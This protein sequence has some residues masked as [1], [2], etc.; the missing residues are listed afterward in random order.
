M[1][2]SQAV[3]S[4]SK[5]DRGRLG[6][7][8]HH[9]GGASGGR[10]ADGVGSTRAHHTKEAAAGCQ[11]GAPSW[12]EPQERH[13]KRS[14]EAYS[15]LLGD[16]GRWPA[17]AVPRSPRTSALAHAGLLL[18]LLLLLLLLLRPAGAAPPPTQAWPPPLIVCVLPQVAWALAKCRGHCPRMPPPTL[19]PPVPPVPPVPQADVASPGRLPLASRP[20]PCSTLLLKPTRMSSFPVST[21]RRVPKQP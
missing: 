5:P 8:E 11:L 9:R 21:G 19:T 7:Q 12:G 1:A 20:G 16:V 13:R 15:L 17:G 4:T 10:R 2:R 6:H 3:L 18:M 14:A